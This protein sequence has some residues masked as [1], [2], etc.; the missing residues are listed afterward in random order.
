MPMIDV[1]A[2]AGTS[3]DKPSLARD[4]AAAVMRWEQVP[5]ISLFQDNTAAWSIANRRPRSL[6]LRNPGG[7]V[8]RDLG[9][10]RWRAGWATK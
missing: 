2:A 7:D 4:L 8:P 3:G 5:P 9:I 1:Y 10:R 6:T